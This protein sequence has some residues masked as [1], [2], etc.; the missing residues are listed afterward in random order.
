MQGRFISYR[1]FGTTYW[2]HLQ[3]SNSPRII[4]IVMSLLFVSNHYA[5][6]EGHSVSMA[7]IILFVVNRI[8]CNVL[9]GS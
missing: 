4:V 2:S 1:L 5:S 3:G 7:C 6:Q 9:I 8:M